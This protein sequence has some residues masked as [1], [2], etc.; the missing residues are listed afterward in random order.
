[1][2]RHRD[3]ALRE[4]TDGWYWYSNDDGAKGKSPFM[5]VAV[6]RC[7]CFIFFFDMYSYM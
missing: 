2:H 4:Q 7:I 5:L 3:C 1:M 6:I